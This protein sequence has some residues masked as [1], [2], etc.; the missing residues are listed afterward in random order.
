MKKVYLS[1]LCLLVFALLVG[2]GFWM[3]GSLQETSSVIPEYVLE[4]AE[5]VIE[6]I[7]AVKNDST[8]LLAVIT[9][10]HYGNG[11][12][13]DGIC[14]AVEAM[15]YIDERVYL[16]A[17]AVLGDYTDGFPSTNHDDAVDDYR[18][19]N[20]LLSMKSLRFVPSMRIQGNHDFCPEHK[21]ETI[22]YIQ[23]HSDGMTWVSEG[24]GYGYRDFEKAK[25]RFVLLN[26]TET[27]NEMIS[28]TT[29]QYQWFANII[30][31]SAKEDAH[32]WQIVVL[33]HH[34]LDWYY[35]DRSYTFARVLNA[36]QNGT[37]YSNE[38]VHCNYENGRN[39]AKIIANFHGH[40]HNLLVDNVHLEN[41]TSH[42]KSGILRIASPEACIN[43]HNQ[44]EGEWKEAKNYPKIMNSAKD[45]SFV[46]YC[47][48]LENYTINAICYGA[49][50]DREVVYYSDAEIYKI[51]QELYNVS[52]SS[53]ENNICEG[54]RFEAEL[55]VH[56]GCE[57]KK[58]KII[59][60]NEDVTESVLHGSN[61]VVENVSG[62]IYIYAK[63]TGAWE[64]Q[65]QIQNALDAGGKPYED[66]RGYK[67]G[68]R[69]N[70][71]KEEVESSASLITGFLPFNKNIDII[72]IKGFP[73]MPTSS[74]YFYTYIEGDS[75]EEK[76]FTDFISRPSYLLSKYPEACTFEFDQSG[77]GIFT[78][79]IPE[80]EKV[81]DTYPSILRESDYIRYNIVNAV[82]EQ[83]VCTFDEEIH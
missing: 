13:T 6:R 72:R 47:I 59:M 34:P 79:N 52:I 57:L 78:I 11:Q 29:E 55:N 62:H 75:T 68:I 12:Y 4:E 5:T 32:E 67:K 66:G 46:V 77:V 50:Y 64:E 25:L 35:N 44:Y 9:D 43:R 56:Q 60:N 48:D 49:G 74:D 80:F 65:N 24:V 17:I 14:N 21:E 31:L 45:T 39:A 63:A 42:N 10:M 71:K 37:S 3:R 38:Y 7:N 53:I 20:K 51:A 58:A 15:A 2:I 70:S 33:S 83:M 23:S 54:E 26:T 76:I 82:E 1:I 61:I 27:G 22:E 69:F 81:S 28:C 40:I 30:D 73:S 16:D 41:V 18:A 19:I 8:F 36:Y